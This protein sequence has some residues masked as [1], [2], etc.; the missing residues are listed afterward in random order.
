[1]HPRRPRRPATRIVVTTPPVESDDE[2]IAR[3]RRLAQ[4]AADRELAGFDATT[5]IEA[6]EANHIVAQNILNLL[7]AAGLTQEELASRTGINVSSINR[8]LKAAHKLTSHDRQNMTVAK[9]FAYARA[10]DVHPAV[11]VMERK[12]EL[13]ERLPVN[14]LPSF[15]EMETMRGVLNQLLAVAIAAMAAPLVTPPADS[16][17]ELVRSDEG[18]P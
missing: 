6:Q 16:P 4:E 14:R 1:M 8:H 9:L 3:V 11:L 2:R 12:T 15:R 5:R 13:P 18:Q 17:I 7:F 10:L